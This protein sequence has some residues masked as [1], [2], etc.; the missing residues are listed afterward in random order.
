MTPSQTAPSQRQ[1]PQAFVHQKTNKRSCHCNAKF[2]AQIAS[3]KT[4]KEHKTNISVS[5]HPANEL[6]KTAPF[7]KLKIS[8]KTHFRPCMMKPLMFKT[9]TP[10]K[11]LLTYRLSTI[12]SQTTLPNSKASAM[13]VSLA[14]LIWI[15]QKQV[16][17]CSIW[18]SCNRGSQLR[19]N[20]NLRRLRSDGTKKSLSYRRFNRHFR[21]KRKHSNCLSHL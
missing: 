18:S 7:L 9:F 6:I 13:L 14:S 1:V 19:S 17:Q 2:T 3:I 21:G 5:C 20:K 4:S 16:R 15:N 10:S 8:T 12:D 11:T